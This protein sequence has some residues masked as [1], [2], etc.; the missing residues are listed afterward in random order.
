[1]ANHPFHWAWA[2]SSKVEPGVCMRG[3]H[4]YEERQWCLSICH[5]YKTFH[6]T[7]SDLCSAIL[8]LGC[9]VCTHVSPFRSL[10]IIVLY[11]CIERWKLRNWAATLYFVHSGV[12]VG[13]LSRCFLCPF[14][15]FLCS[16]L[17]LGSRS[18]SVDEWVEHSASDASETNE[19]K[20][21]IVKKLTQCPYRF[22]IICIPLIFVA[23]HSCDCF[24]VSVFH[25]LRFCA[26]LYSS[27]VPHSVCMCC[28]SLVLPFESQSDW[29]Y[30]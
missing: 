22:I 1:M 16:Y 28:V 13:P 12:I 21:I 14:S 7:I 6:D 24:W 5:I 23:S 18:Q 9:V 30:Q 11:M 26:S 20:K 17:Y 4:W 27:F 19:R 25:S 29:K 3:E 2:R 8:M 10:A 15:F